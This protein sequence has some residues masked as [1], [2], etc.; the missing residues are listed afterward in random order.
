MNTPDNDPE[1][2]AV[3]NSGY[4]M[5][6]EMTDP[7]PYGIP[8]QPVKPGLTKRGKTALAI[9]A[10]VL[11]AGGLMSYQAYAS[12]M[13]ESQAKADEIALKEKALEL[14]TMREMNRAAEAQKK[15][16]STE[17]KARQTS[18]D[19][20]IKDKE[21]L[22]GKG[23]GSPTYRDVVDL[24][25]TQYAGPATDGSDMQA[26]GSAQDTGAGGGV[27]DGLLVGLGVLGLGAV[28]A[29]RKGSRPATS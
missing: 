13:A 1:F 10:T 27:N 29:V 26:A 12:S 5:N 28:F 6:T 20:C 21:D 17:I 7:N 14:E 3:I 9:G 18:V 15:T 24:C 25:T 8:A 4:G 2:S 23:L 11:A 19:K 16:Q 22:V